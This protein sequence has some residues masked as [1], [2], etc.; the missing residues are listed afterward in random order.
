MLEKVLSYN[1]NSDREHVVVMVVVVVVYPPDHGSAIL[2]SPEHSSLHLHW[3]A[4]K[5]LTT[6]QYQMPSLKQ[7]TASYF[8]T[9]QG[10]GTV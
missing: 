7:G 10:N 2:N 9:C 3:Q 6:M 5:H 8:C 1:V 4:V